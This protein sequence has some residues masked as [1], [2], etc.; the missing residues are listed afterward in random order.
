M[1][2]KKGLSSVVANVL[3]VLL[4]V[5]AVGILMAIILPTLQDSSDE[6]QARTECQMMNLE[7]TSCSGASGKVV[8]SR[9]TG[10]PDEIDGVRIIVEGQGTCD[11]L[12]VMDELAIETFD[13]TDVSCLGFALTEDDVVTVGALIG[14]GVCEI[15]GIVPFTCDA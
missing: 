12:K 3:I 2:N 5:A 1:F 6:I 14:D 11:F 9:G 7:I 8:V 10:G 13:T 4:A 15:M